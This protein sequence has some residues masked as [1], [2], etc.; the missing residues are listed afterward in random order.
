[1]PIEI[2]IPRCNL[3]SYGHAQNAFF[4][5]NSEEVTELKAM[6]IAA[7][8][9]YAG[10]RVIEMKAYPD[11]K[12]R[13]KQLYGLRSKAVHRAA[14][15]HIEIKDLDNLSYWLAWIIISM[16]ALSARRLS[17][18]EAGPGANL[19]AGPAGP[20]R[21]VEE[22]YHPGVIAENSRQTTLRKN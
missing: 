21:N 20:T 19:A 8:L 11:L 10:F 3:L 7:T 22:R 2:Q 5:I 13:I 14:F 15:G 6:G 9:T 17:H 16:A 12:R 4:A 18:T 1:M